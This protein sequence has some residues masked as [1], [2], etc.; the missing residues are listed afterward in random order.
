MGYQSFF[1]NVIENGN[2]PDEN[3]NIDNENGIMYLFLTILLF[4]LVYLD[5][6]IFK[7]ASD[8]YVIN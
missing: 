8:S 3:E 7:Y 4:S 2:I 5:S 6:H 1:N